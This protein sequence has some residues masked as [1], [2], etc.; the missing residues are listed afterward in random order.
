MG[1][2]VRR[3]DV[4][5][6]DVFYHAVRDELVGK[7]E[8]QRNGRNVQPTV[9]KFDDADSRSWQPNAEKFQPNSNQQRRSREKKRHIKRRKPG[10]LAARGLYESPKRSDEN[11]HSTWWCR[12]F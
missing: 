9:R 3:Y 4:A 11:G 1:F 2:D 10:T 7:T 5:V 6:V 12:V 8:N